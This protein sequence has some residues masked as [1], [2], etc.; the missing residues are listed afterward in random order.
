MKEMGQEQDWV[1]GGV[2]CD[3]GPSEPQSTGPGAWE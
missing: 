3:A 1:A 2:H